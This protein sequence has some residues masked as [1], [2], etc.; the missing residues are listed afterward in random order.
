M[1]IIRTVKEIV[2]DN[3][4]NKCYFWK[5]K[6]IEREKLIDIGRYLKSIYNA[7]G[8]VSVNSEMDN[9]DSLLA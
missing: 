4:D 8:H 5:R 7:R 2:M 9:H 3:E 1:I 6:N